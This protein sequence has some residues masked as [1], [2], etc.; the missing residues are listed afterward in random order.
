MIQLQERRDT[1]LSPVPCA[2]CGRPVSHMDGRIPGALAGGLC[3]NHRD[4]EGKR[5]KVF[6]FIRQVACD[7]I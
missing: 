5:E 2:L 6:T 1:R 4:K 7:H 3:G